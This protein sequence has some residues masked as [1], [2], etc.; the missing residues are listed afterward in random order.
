MDISSVEFLYNWKCVQKYSIDDRYA[1]DMLKNIHSC[2][3]INKTSIFHVEI[4]FL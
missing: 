2:I 3:L 1:K 4:Q